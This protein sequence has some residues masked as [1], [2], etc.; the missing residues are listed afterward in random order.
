MVLLIDTRQ[1]DN[2]HSLKN[3]WFAE[4]GIQTNRCTL[5]CGDYQ[6]AGDGSVAID[7]KADLLEVIN[8]IQF[9]AMSKVAIGEAVRDICEKHKVASGHDR[10]IFHLIVD[11]DSG[12]YPES[13]I[14][15]YCFTNKIPDE[16]MKGF[17]DLYLKRHGFFHRGLVRAKQYGVKLYILVEEDGIRSVRD[18]F[19]W[20]NP[21]LLIMRNSDELIGF[22]R[23]GRPKFKK[24]QAYPKAMPGSTLAKAMLTMEKRYGCTFVFTDKAHA[25]EKIV[26]LL[27]G[28]IASGENKHL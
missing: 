4:N 28:D 10:N 13:Q 25:G 5:V 11:D 22:Y 21:R 1:Q 6:I 27:V 2:K 23:N 8:D 9:K 24:I 15:E 16:A 26:E 12:R 7:S 14:T 17:L 3:R 18:V 20:T 19:R